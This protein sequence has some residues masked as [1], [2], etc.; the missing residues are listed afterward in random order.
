MSDLKTLLRTGDPARIDRGM[1]LDE[2]DRMRRVLLAASRQPAIPTR[3]MMPAFAA[4]LLLTVVG[5]V[6][7]VGPVPA[8]AVDPGIAR[9]EPATHGP[10]TRQ[11]LFAGPKGTRVIWT[12]NPKFEMR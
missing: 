3:V 11:L 10:D 7:I 4:A 8:P 5:G 2:V 12:F 1:P 9:V 6:W